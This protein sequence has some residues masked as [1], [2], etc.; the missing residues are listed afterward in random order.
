MVKHVGQTKNVFILISIYKSHIE[1]DFI[2]F[3]SLSLGL[4]SYIFFIQK[5]SEEFFNVFKI[6]QYI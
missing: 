3:K 5:F 4:L 6:I 1:C 2:W